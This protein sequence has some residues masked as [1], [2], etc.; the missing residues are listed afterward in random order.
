MS[1]AISEDKAISTHSDAVEEETNNNVPT[2]PHI[3]NE[4]LLPRLWRSM[5][6]SVVQVTYK[7]EKV[8]ME[9]NRDTVRDL[10]EVTIHLLKSRLEW[11]R[12]LAYL[13]AKLDGK[14]AEL[15]VLHQYVR[16][17]AKIGRKRKRVPEGQVKLTA[18][19]AVPLSTTDTF[20]LAD[21][22]SN[23]PCFMSDEQ[24]EIPVSRVDTT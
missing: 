20:E 10:N 23:L 4:D 17:H 13:E 6:H 15:E 24:Q 19:D 21:A 16:G 22:R 5:A 18:I 1:S 12:T 3:H 9:A 14:A 8:A 2:T 11:S 7:A